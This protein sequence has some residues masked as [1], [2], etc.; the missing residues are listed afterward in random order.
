MSKNHYKSSIDPKSG[1]VTMDYGTAGKLEFKPS[2]FSKEFQIMAMAMG[3]K[4][5]I[6]DTSSG[7]KPTT[8]AECFKIHKAE[9]DRLC[10]DGATWNIKKNGESVLVEDYEIL[11]VEW[12]IENYE[13]VKTDA[14][15]LKLM[16]ANNRAK[17]DINDPLPDGYKAI[18]G[19]NKA[20]GTKQK[21]FLL[22]NADKQ[23]LVEKK[24]IGDLTTLTL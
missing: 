5:K 20:M 13:T 2:S 4:S 16:K 18:G 7:K 24:I 15:A 1:K 9:H 17:L 8:N 19:Y 11:L 14:D 10:V 21:N 23:W 6:A 22:D 12:I 3:L